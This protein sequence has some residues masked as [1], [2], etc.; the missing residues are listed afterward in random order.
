[1]SV[2]NTIVNVE[3]ITNEP[4]IYTLEATK[5]E[6]E[7]ISLRLNLLSLEKLNAKLQLER[8]EHIHLTGMVKAEVIQE[9]VRTLQPI[10]QQLEFLVHESFKQDPESSPEETDTLTTEDLTEPLEGKELD[11]GEVVI[12][13]LSLNLDPFPVTQTSTFVDY[14]EPSEESSPFRVLRNSK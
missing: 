11:L 10:S 6:R 13:L 1:M 4:Q 7:I 12:Q 8:K 14:Q 9:C 2:L 3:N 5:E